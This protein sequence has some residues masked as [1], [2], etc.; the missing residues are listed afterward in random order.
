MNQQNLDFAAESR[1]HSYEAILTK[2]GARR[3]EVYEAIKG[4]AEGRT[5]DELAYFLGRESY[6]I[7]P[8]L[9]EL[10]KAGL[11]EAVG[12]RRSERTGK[13]IS[14]WMVKNGP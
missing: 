11:I 10:R 9:T 5:A 13:N 14:V 3:L 4:M 2:A 6:V 12:R 7:R 1:R 8:R